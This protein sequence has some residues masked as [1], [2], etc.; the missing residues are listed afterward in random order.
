[1]LLFVESNISHFLRYWDAVEL[2]TWDTEQ[3]YKEIKVEAKK[4]M[5]EHEEKQRTYILFLARLFVVKSG[6]KAAST[7]HDTQTYKYA[8]GYITLN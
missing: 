4:F 1:M 6:D 3:N 7:Q 8:E 2:A 5:K